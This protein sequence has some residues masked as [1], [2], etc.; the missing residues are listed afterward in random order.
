MFDP[1]KHILQLHGKAMPSTRLYPHRLL[2]GTS[3][4]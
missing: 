3:I 4:I 2:Q 1:F